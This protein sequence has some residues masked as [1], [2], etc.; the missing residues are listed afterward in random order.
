LEQG[1]LIMEFVDTL[2]KLEIDL[3]NQKL[4]ISDL[5]VKLIK[6]LLIDSDKIIV[7]KYRVFVPDFKF[8]NDWENF[9]GSDTVSQDEAVEDW[10]KQ[11]SHVFLDRKS[12]KPLLYTFIIDKE[13]KLFFESKRV[14]S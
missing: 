3:E 10:D 8:E 12:R 6:K 2:P 7:E 11:P 14:E 1:E 5:E 13:N 4:R 9:I